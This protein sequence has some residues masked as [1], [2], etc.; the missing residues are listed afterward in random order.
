MIRSLPI[1]PDASALKL[2]ALSR[3]ALAA[4]A[5]TASSLGPSPLLVVTDLDA[6]SLGISIL[7]ASSFG[8]VSWSGAMVGA[9]TGPGSDGE[10]L[11]MSGS[12]DA[13]T[14]VGGE[15]VAPVPTESCSAWVSSGLSSLTFK[16]SGKS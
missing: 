1:V 16:V 6:S 4:A 7:G 2:S 13:S 10:K 11:T 3:S 12:R 5:L 9:S 8:S 15:T 14:W